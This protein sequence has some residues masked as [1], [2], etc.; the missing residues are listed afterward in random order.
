MQLEAIAYHPITRIALREE[1][2]LGRLGWRCPG[3]NTEC[4]GLVAK[5]GEQEAGE[6]REASCRCQGAGCADRP[7]PWDEGSAGREVLPASAP[8]PAMM[9]P[10]QTLTPKD[11]VHGNPVLVITQLANEAI[12][13][14]TL[15]VAAGCSL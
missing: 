12:K 3:G 8:I 1:V 14:W 7:V 13:D 9:L 6:C 11:I 5:R 15:S 2:W 4:E 10:A